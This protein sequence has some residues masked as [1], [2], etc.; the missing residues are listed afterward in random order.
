MT[1]KQIRVEM[2]TIEAMRFHGLEDHTFEWMKNLKNPRRRGDY[3]KKLKR[4]RLS[5]RYVSEAPASDIMNTILHEIAHALVDRNA[6]R[7]HMHNY[8]WQRQA[9]A[10]GC[11]GE[12]LNKTKLKRI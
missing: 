12:R 6:H 3:Y 9:K 11:T 10:V 8:V 2:L 4:V 1:P 5:P 7:S